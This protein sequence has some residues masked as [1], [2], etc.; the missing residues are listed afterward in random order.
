MNNCCFLGRL[1]AEPELR[2]TQTNLPV[3]SFTIAVPR[4][5]VKDTTDFIDCVAWRATGEFVSKWF[6]KGDPI[7][8]NGMLTLRQW[9]DKDGNNRRASEIVVDKVYFA[10][11]KPSRT[12]TPRIPP[13][14][15]QPAQPPI[16]KDTFAPVGDPS[17]EL[18]F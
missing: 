10:G 18:P 1:T 9:K 7:C 11:N 3:C 2:H 13:T 6:H 12:E 17:D 15:H 16:T 5:N 8:V 4:P 14:D